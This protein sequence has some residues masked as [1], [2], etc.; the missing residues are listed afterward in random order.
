[1]LKHDKEL[2][3]VLLIDKLGDLDGYMAIG[4]LFKCSNCRYHIIG[5]KVFLKNDFIRERLARHVWPNANV[6]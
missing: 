5:P 3:L 4:H 1:M 6:L 2:D